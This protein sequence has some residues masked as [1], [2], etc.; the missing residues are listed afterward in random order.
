[1]WQRFG[2]LGLPHAFT[3]LKLLKAHF[4]VIRV[5]HGYGKTQNGYHGYRYGSR[6]WHTEAYRYPYPRYHRYTRVNYSEV[7]F[8]IYYFYF[9]FIV[10]FYHFLSFSFGMC[11]CVTL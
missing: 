8:T 4:P 10:T 9:I 1:M 11:L 5:R 7:S 3:A 2:V 6:L